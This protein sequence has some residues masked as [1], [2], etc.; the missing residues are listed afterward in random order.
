VVGYDDDE[1]VAPVMIPPLTT[2]AIPQVAMGAEG[3]RRLLAQ[4]GGAP[5]APQQVLVPCP[6]IERE[7]VAAP[8][9]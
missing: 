8:R 6:L 2:V 7:S 9:T 3:M 5:S 4:I 1:N